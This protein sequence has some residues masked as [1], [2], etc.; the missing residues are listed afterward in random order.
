MYSM[1]YYLASTAECV[2]GIYVLHAYIVNADKI[3]K[4]FFAFHLDTDSPL[5]LGG[6]V[7]TGFPPA[8]L[9]AS[10]MPDHLLPPGT[11]P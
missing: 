3:Q 2:I 8:G 9:L 11:C 10:P 1:Y 6:R 5:A 7:Q 4:G